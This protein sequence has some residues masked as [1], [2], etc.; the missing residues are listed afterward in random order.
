[1]KDEHD[2]R[3]HECDEHG[4]ACGEIA[5]ERIRYFNGRYL[6][7]RDFRDEQR[8][9]LS[10][11]YLHNR[12]L[13]GWGVVCGLR[14]VPH[15]DKDCEDDWVKLTPGIA[16]DC[17]GREVVVSEAV[18]VRPPME[19]VEAYG[20]GKR[21]Y[22][23]LRFHPKAVECV[24]V[25]DPESTCDDIRKENS[26]IR[27]GHELRWVWLDDEEE[28]KCGAWK[29]AAHEK[30]EGAAAKRDA[31]KDQHHGKGK[32]QGK[33]PQP[34]Y[35]DDC[36]EVSGCLE[37]CCPEHHCV[38]LARVTRGDRKP[39]GKWKLDIEM[40]G[41]RTL[42]PPADY[43]THICAIN[44]PHGG[45]VTISDLRSK[46]RWLRV[47]F[48][49]KL[50]DPP[51]EAHSEYFGAT[52]VS[53]GTFRVEY[54][55]GTEDLDFVPYRNAPYQ[56][57]DDRIAVYDMNPDLDP[58]RGRQRGR[59]FGYLINKTVFITILCDFIEDCHGLPV[60]GDFLSGTLPTGDG[61]KGGTFHS[62][63]HVVEDPAPDDQQKT[64]QGR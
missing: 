23:C 38:L 61:T 34:D 16:I 33:G 8:F 9:H 49:R 64:N 56:D 4:P 35:R 36:D 20:G 53:A 45:T 43:L 1:M 41:R 21:L 5:M 39:N 11:H 18:A 63:F 50:A 31:G 17:C 55:G 25:L 60:D 48:D 42:P 28:Q 13:H 58:S 24:P 57:G 40:R 30:E 46:L 26:R 19:E 52:G 29:R 54:G 47:T 62:W 10:R 27:E 3:E 7:A 14:V 37:S 32:D 2:G 22:L 44:W 12:L 59:D 51:P 15:P 6:S